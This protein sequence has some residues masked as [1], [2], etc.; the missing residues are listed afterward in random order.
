[1]VGLKRIAGFLP[2]P[3]IKPLVRAWRRM[4]G[5][6]EIH[7]PALLSDPDRLAIDVG[8]NAGNSAHWLAPPSQG[9]IAFEPNLTLARSIE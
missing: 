2:D 9:C 8:A 7:V 5:N 1:M 6:P 3:V 4:R